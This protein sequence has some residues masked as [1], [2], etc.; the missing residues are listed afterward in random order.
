L[1]RLVGGQYYFISGTVLSYTFHVYA[2][3]TVGSERVYSANPLIITGSSDGS[4]GTNRWYS[5]E[6]TWNAVTGADGYRVISYQGT[7]PNFNYYLDTTY[8]SF[9]FGFGSAYP[10]DSVS[11]GNINSYPTYT[12]YASPHTFG[13]DIYVDATTGN[14]ISTKSAQFTGDVTANSFI[15]TGGVSTEFLKADGSVDSTTYLDTTT[16]STTYLALDQTTPQTTVGTFTFPKIKAVS[17]DEMSGASISSDYAFAIQDTST[18]TFYKSGWEESDYSH[19]KHFHED[20]IGGYGDSSGTPVYLVRNIFDGDTGTRTAYAIYQDDGSSKVIE[21]FLGDNGYETLY[22]ANNGLFQN[23]LTV[24]TTSLD[25]TAALAVV[26]SVGINTT[27]PTAA[28]EVTGSVGGTAQDTPASGSF[29]TTYYPVTPSSVTGEFHNTYAA[30]GPTIDY[31]ASSYFNTTYSPVA[32]ATVSGD[33]NGYSDTFYDVGDGNIYRTSDSGVIG[34]IDYNTGLVDTSAGPD[35]VDEISYRYY[36]TDTFYDDGYGNLYSSNDSHQL[37]AITYAT[38]VVDTSGYYSEIISIIDY[39]YSSST[40]AK[41]NGDTTTTG[42]SKADTVRVD[43]GDIY[44]SNPADGRYHFWSEVGAP[45]TGFIA[46]NNTNLKG[47]A[48]SVDT[49]NDITYIDTPFPMNFRRYADSVQFLTIGADK[50][51]TVEGNLKLKAGLVTKYVAKTANYTLTTTDYLVNC[52]ANSFDVTLPTA[53]G[54]TG[55]T[56][57]IKNSGTGLITVNTTSSQTIDGQASG[58]IKLN[59]WENLTV[60][61]TGANWIIL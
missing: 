41:F 14:L 53:A 57:N 52:T 23:H 17:G 30:Q 46:S 32:G 4:S 15:K 6:T 20:I 33:I 11:N 13:P 8:T 21:G 24:G 40:V 47:F 56:Y 44:G 16:A 34:T 1:S 58:V 26:G 18:N 35:S 7:D 43:T 29:T 2:Y 60:M 12:D 59:Q 55:Q 51:L 48:F 9:K 61:S 50:S 10:K 39:T 28:L 5:F 45:L 42:Q 54:V 37:G 25:T 19:G 49:T 3:K 22:Y 36:A 38:G 31:P 27:S